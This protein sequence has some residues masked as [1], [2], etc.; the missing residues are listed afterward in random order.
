M[1][2]LKRWRDAVAS[3]L[4]VFLHVRATFAFLDA[5][6]TVEDALTIIACIARLAGWF[7]P[8]CTGQ[9]EA[10]RDKRVAKHI[11]NPDI[12]LP[13][14]CT[15]SGTTARAVGHHSHQNTSRI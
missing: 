2:A 7:S 15:G 1:S 12:V 4:P 8:T 13:P 10:Q 11:S 3:L 14:Q 5:A 9:D 6:E